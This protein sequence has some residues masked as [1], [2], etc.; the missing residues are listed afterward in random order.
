MIHLTRGIDLVVD[1]DGRLQQS[2]AQAAALGARP[3]SL[4][5]TLAGG[6]DRH[7]GLVVN[8]SDISRTFEAALAEDVRPGDTWELLCWARNVLQE[9]FGDFQVVR[10]KAVLSDMV[11]VSLINGAKPMVHITTK[12]EIAASHR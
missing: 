7:S 5:V 8:V 9:H 3:L 10:I 2:P 12:Y 6:V 4:W 1:A 11:S